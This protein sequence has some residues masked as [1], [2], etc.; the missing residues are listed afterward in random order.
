MHTSI[1]DSLLTVTDTFSIL[2]VRVII[3]YTDS[4]FI[5]TD[6][7]NI[8]Y[9]SNKQSDLFN[10]LLQSMVYTVIA[11]FGYEADNQECMFQYLH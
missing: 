11:V 7:R 3:T 6:N 5:W 1:I 9:H 8:C 2:F 4:S 10:G